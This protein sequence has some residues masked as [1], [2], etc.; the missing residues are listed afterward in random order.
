VSADRAIGRLERI[1]RPA[2]LVAD[3]PV[4]ESMDLHRARP[5]EMS[6]RFG[7]TVTGSG[8]PVVSKATDQATFE[9]TLTWRTETRRDYEA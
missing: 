6:L 2:M 8:E 1:F 5:T 3:A 4:K 9:V 7:L